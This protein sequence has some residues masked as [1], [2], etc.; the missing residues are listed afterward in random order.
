MAIESEINGMTQAG[1]FRVVGSAVKYLVG[2]ALLTAASFAHSSTPEEWDRLFATAT[3]TCIHASGLNRPK[4]SPP[5]D[6]SDKVMVE[7]RGY[8]PQPHMDNAP[9]RSVCLYDKLTKRAEVM[10]APLVGR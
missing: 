4:A 2:T 7:V 3:H 10:D 1:T 5:V 8:W 6:F 9:A